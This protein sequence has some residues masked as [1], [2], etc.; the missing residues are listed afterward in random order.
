MSFDKTLWTT[1]WV[2]KTTHKKLTDIGTKGQSYD[3]ILDMLIN[4]YEES[5]KKDNSVQN[6]TPVKK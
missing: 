1:V 2:K 6:S 5:N 4:V 3:D